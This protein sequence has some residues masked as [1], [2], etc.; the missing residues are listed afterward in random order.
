M[1]MFK[2]LMLIAAAAMAF[3]GCS[4]DEF[5]S[6]SASKKQTIAFSSVITRTAFGE[7]DGNTYPTLWTGN[8]KIRI[9]LNNNANNGTSKEATITTEDN[10]KATWTAEIT[11]DESGEYT[12]YAL[13]P[14]VA[15]NSTRADGWSVKIPETQTPSENSCDEAAQ[16]LVAKSETYTEFPSSVE[17]HFKHFTAYGK[18]TLKNLN[19]GDAKVQNISLTAE[20][21]IVGRFNYTFATD[22]IAENSAS[23][24]LTINTDKTEDVWFAIRPCDLA[25]SA[26]KVVV[27]TDKGTFTKEVE[28]P[29]DY[30]FKAGVIAKMTINMEGIA[31]EGPDYWTLVTNADELT[32][33]DLVIIAAKDYN[34]AMST[35]Q[36]SN[37]RGQAGISKSDD[38]TTATIGEGVQIFTVEDGV[39][40]GTL[41]F[42]TGSGYIY[43][44]STSKN[45]LRTQTNLDANASWRLTFDAGYA[46]LVAQGTNTRATMQYNQSSSLFACYS[47]ASQKQIALY[48]K[49]ASTAPTFEVLDSTVEV[50]DLAT[51]AEFTVK[52][53]V[54]WTATI[55][56][57]A[58]TF[59]NGSTT[60]TGEGGESVKVNF[61]ANTVAEAK[62]Y[63]VTVSTDAEVETNAYEVVINQAGA[64]THVYYVPVTEV[65]AGKKYLIV[66]NNSG[67][68][69]AAT[70]LTSNYGYL[71]RT[72]VAVTENG[73]DSNAT[74]DAV[75]FT[76]NATAT[77][78]VYNIV[79]KNGK[80]YYQ[81]G[82]YDSF[83]VQATLPTSGADW[84]IT[85]D[86]NGLATIKNTSVNKWA[87][88]DTNYNTYGS[89]NT[90]KGILP[91]LYMLQE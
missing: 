15:M 27:T 54:A 62:T 66:A 91:Q 4:N 69:Y 9:G 17:M 50:N 48:Y 72:Q 71:Q 25:T 43:A 33:G 1:K 61:A 28:V 24:T 60:M 55:T 74:T 68:Y 86:A 58:A 45:Y 39:N 34:V 31:L 84:A 44:A 64:T 2:S 42:N 83:N 12:L 89:Y 56:E 80:Y 3:T 36:N 53:N 51:S 76:I 46:K 18:L 88:Y 90:Q 5:D 19:L 78:G 57:G 65:T 38:K 75:A 41:A 11:D 10:V 81:T 77:E 47:S 8:E 16:I 52:G 26:L 14:A 23:A 73:I 6:T 32:A 29:E 40:A 7:A 87:Q 85:I 35:T 63:K 13:C 67:T 22:A 30:A 20:A 79:D 21:N 70:P 82:T 49:K 37:N 59:D